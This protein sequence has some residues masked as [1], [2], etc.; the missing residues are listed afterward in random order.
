MK[1]SDLLLFHRLCFEMLQQYI[2][3]R[4]QIVICLSL[5]SISMKSVIYLMC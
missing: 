5:S 3:P 1:V 4:Y 2:D